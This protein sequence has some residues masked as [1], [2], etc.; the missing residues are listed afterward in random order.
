MKN[1]TNEQAE[2]S[3]EQIQK[4]EWITPEMTELNLN[5]KNFTAVEAA[6]SGPLPS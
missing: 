4:K 5:A 1:T 3:E 2:A 6:T